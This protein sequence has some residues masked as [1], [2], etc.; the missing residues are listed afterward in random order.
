MPVEMTFH[1]LLL[2]L[3]DCYIYKTTLRLLVIET[4]LYR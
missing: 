4:L 3:E 1:I 2:N